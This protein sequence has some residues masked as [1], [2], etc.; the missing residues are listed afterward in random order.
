MRHNTHHT[1]TNK[2]LKFNI[3]KKILLMFF[4]SLMFFSCNKENSFQGDEFNI[5]GT[6]KIKTIN[7]FSSSS[8]SEPYA[9]NSY[10]Y[11]KNWNL[12]K[13]L[14]SDYPKPLFASYTYEYSEKGVLLNKK[15]NA[16]EGVNYPD[17]TESDFILI[18]EYK[19][20][21]QG[22]NKIELEYRRNELTDS[23]VYSYTNNLLISEYHYNLEDGTDWSIVY[24]YDSNKNKTKET[25]NPDGICTIFTYEGSVI[26]TST[27]YD[28]NG[29]LLVEL[30]FVYSKS[31]DKVIVESNYKGPYGDFITE[32]TTYKDGNMIEYIKYH[33]TFQGEEWYCNRYEYY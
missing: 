33:P 2:S 23:V 25:L 4:F 26:K 17:Q 5:H 19:Y 22:N 16:I 27:E 28:R 9:F 18:R 3:M 10:S 29:S 30:T 20:S 21:Y 1:N 14:I 12:K 11:D 24:E 6:G 31:N 13:V 15:Y 8:D 7:I 32:K